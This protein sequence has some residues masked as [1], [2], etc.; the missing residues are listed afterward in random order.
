MPRTTALAASAIA[1]VNVILQRAGL[2]K[3]DFVT[4]QLDPA[5]L[6]RVEVKLKIERQG[7]VHASVTVDNP[8]TLEILRNDRS[9][10]ERALQN[11]GLSTDSG[12]LSF[13]LRGDGNANTQGGFGRFQRGGGDA[14]DPS[15]TSVQ[16]LDVIPVAG[17][18]TNSGR[19]DLRV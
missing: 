14:P 3:S 7:P 16:T 4:V 19:L 2:A 5:E 18:W 11:A 10:L 6:G 17:G 1:Q 15:A 8:R 9:S 13:N 12:S